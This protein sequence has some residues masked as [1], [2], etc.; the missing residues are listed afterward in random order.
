MQVVVSDAVLCC[1]AFGGRSFFRS[2]CVSVSSDQRSYFDVEDR[3]FCSEC[4]PLYLIGVVLALSSSL[5]IIIVIIISTKYSNSCGNRV[6]DILFNVT[7]VFVLFL[8]SVIVVAVVIDI[9]MDILGT[10]I[11]CCT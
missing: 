8:L 9:V 11:V 5:I 4:L 7:V 6:G 3:S 10:S 2:K 1:A